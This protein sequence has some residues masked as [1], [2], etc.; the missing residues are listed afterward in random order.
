M[1]CVTTATAKVPRLVTLITRGGRPKVC[2]IAKASKSHSKVSCERF[3][4]DT[5][6]TARAAGL[7]MLGLPRLPPCRTTASEL[8]SEGDRGAQTP[9]RGRVLVGGVDGV[10]DHPGRADHA[11]VARQAFTVGRIVC[12]EHRQPF[13]LALEE[14]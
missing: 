4:Y 3:R 2:P 6:R 7:N 11:G 12:S 5:V 14:L 13:T 10:A 9:L 1:V 8:T